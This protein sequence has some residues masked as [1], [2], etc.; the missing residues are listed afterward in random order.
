[1]GASAPTIAVIA[2]T[3]WGNR[4][5][6][7]MLTTTIGVMHENCPDARFLAYSYY[8]IKDR[9]LIHD[10]AVEVLDAR[11]LTLALKYF[12]VSLLAAILDMIGIRIP[13]PHALDALRKA[14]VLLDIGGITFADGRAL[15]LLFNIFTILPAM[16]LKTPVIKL[17]QAMGPF[18]T[19]LNRA[20]A[21]FFLK[22]C[23]HVF[24]RG[25]GTAK[26]LQDLGLPQDHWSQAA[27]VAM[28]YRPSFT[29]SIENQTRISELTEKLDTLRSQGKTIVAL[30]PSILVMEKSRNE[31]I[32]YGQ[33]FGGLVNHLSQRNIHP[34]FLPNATREG[35]TS[36]RNNDILAIE[37]IRS[38]CRDQ[39]SA[40]VLASVDWVDY[41]INTRSVRELI[42]RSDVL[43]TSRFHAMVSGLAL[44]VPTLVVGWSHKYMETLADFGMDHLAFDFRS[45]AEDLGAM[46]DEILEKKEA[47]KSQILSKLPSVRQSSSS[48]FLYVKDFLNCYPE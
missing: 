46:V 40:E 22:R 28:L 15:F 41:D 21:G 1:M 39:L 27:D 16:L 38:I 30:S 44:G 25:A 42:S 14:D 43:L 3:I 8:P 17:A 23:K 45:P 32:P 11:P 35:S 47:F 10:E 19:T 5:A 26:N 20:L 6:E 4:G 36:P 48:Q 33:L 7:S 2:G 29:L 31:G 34:V 37:E 18:K 9:E 24:A 13:L 12:P